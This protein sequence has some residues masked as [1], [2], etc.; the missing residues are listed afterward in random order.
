M[1][2]IITRLVVKKCCLCA[3]RWLT[4][5]NRNVEISCDFDVEVVLPNGSSL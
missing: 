4:D 5:I 2:M 3:V 1:V